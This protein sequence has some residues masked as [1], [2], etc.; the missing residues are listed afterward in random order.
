VGN[1]AVI[2]HNPYRALPSRGVAEKL[3]SVAISILYVQL[4]LLLDYG[5]SFCCQSFACEFQ[6]S[7]SSSEKLEVFYSKQTFKF[8]YLLSAR[9]MC[10]A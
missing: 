2:L 1:P 7:L 6:I 9:Y 8:S 3:I 5:G 4:F 10:I